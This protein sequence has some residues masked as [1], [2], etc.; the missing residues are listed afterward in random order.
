MKSNNRQEEKFMR[1]F[2]RK[3]EIIEASR[4]ETGKKRI[5]R[6]IGAIKEETRDVG[7]ILKENIKKTLNRSEQMSDLNNIMCDRLLKGSQSFERNYKPILKKNKHDYYR[8]TASLCCFISSIILII[9]TISLVAYSTDKNF[10]ITEGILGGIAVTFLLCSIALFLYKPEIKGDIGTSI[11]NGIII[12]H[13][14]T[15]QSADK[16]L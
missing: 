3:R 1:I 8:K 10:I 4:N 12:Q 5:E 6:D 11:N 16:L 15:N 9:T 13:S 2:K 7:A 14:S